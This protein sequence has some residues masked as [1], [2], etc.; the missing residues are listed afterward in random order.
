MN[1]CTGCGSILQDKDKNN[2]G[3]TS[4]I[5]NNL[6]ERCFMIKNYNNYQKVISDNTKYVDIL[7]NINITNDL[8]VLVID[9]FNIP[10]NID[11][12]K[13]YINNN[14]LLVLTKRDILPKSLNDSNLLNYFSDLNVVDKVV[15][16]SNKNYNFDLLLNKINKYKTSNN[17]YIVGYTNAGKSTMINKMIY[18]YSNINNI[19]T[20]S[21]LPSTTLDTIK[22]DIN[23]DL[24]L[25][26]TPGLLYENSIIN[27]LDI[28]LLK[29][30]VPKKEIKPITY[31][32]KT[33]Q[34][35]IINDFLFIKCTDKTNLTLYI[36]NNL[37]I[38]RKYK[39]LDN[40]LLFNKKINVAK[41]Q[42][43]VINE[44]GFIKST[45]DIDLEISSIYE[46]DIY[47]RDSII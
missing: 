19:L 47:T 6:C 41:D 13:K 23:D 27:E 42:D 17:V 35:I 15:I 7:K 16:S 20:T 12:I 2:I 4:N 24:T 45:S 11:L 32:I 28:K 37:K 10:K 33:N 8:V 26:D 29:K 36:S 3:Y 25:I 21:I 9:I 14:I 40:I 22:I 31:Q 43:L 34:T 1:K 30:L 18:N 39:D 38:D 46:L 5:N 44:V